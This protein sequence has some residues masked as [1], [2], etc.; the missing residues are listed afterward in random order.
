MNHCNYKIS[1]IIIISHDIQTINIGG[2]VLYQCRAVAGIPSPVITWTRT[3]LRPLT[4][5]TEVLSGWVLRIT[6]VT[7]VE[8]GECSHP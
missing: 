6:R 8:E 7:G 5:N 2:S 3:D 4:S 1:I